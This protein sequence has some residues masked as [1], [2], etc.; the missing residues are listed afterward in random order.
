MVR[1]VSFFS[2][3]FNSYQL[4]YSVVEKEAL[5]LIWALQHFD[6]YVGLGQP[7]VVYTDHNP[8]TFLNSLNLFSDGFIEDTCCWFPV[9]PFKKMYDNWPG[10]L[11]FGPGFVWFWF[12]FVLLYTS[13][14]TTVHYI[15]MHSLH[16]TPLIPDCFMLHGIYANSC[17][18]LILFLSPCPDQMVDRR[19]EMMSAARSSAMSPRDISPVKTSTKIQ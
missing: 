11:H 9:S 2:R 17:F 7:I 4:N 6:V 19:R 5:A 3:K 16:F 14:I 18:F 10:R 1:P 12:N 8:L 13:N 15:F